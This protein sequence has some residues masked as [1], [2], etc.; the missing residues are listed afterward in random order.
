MP[1]TCLN[2]RQLFGKKYRLG[3]DAAREGY[4]KDPWLLEMPC[5]RGTIYPWSS[6]LLAVEVDYHPG[7]ARKLARLGLVKVQDG[8][9]EKT[10]VFPLD[11]FAEVAAIVRP[12]R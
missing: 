10:F 6:T 4:D 1:P 9:H 11:R 7:V 5:Y 12:R 8:N 3:W 2:L